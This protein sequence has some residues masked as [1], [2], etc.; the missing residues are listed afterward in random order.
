MKTILSNIFYTSPILFTLM[1]AILAFFDFKTFW[2]ACIIGSLCEFFIIGPLLKMITIK[3][4]TASL[5][6]IHKNERMCFK[7]NGMPSGHT[8]NAVF[9]MV[10]VLYYVMSCSKSYVK[11]FAILLASV[12]IVAGVAWQRIHTEMHSAKQVG[13]GSL[14][15][16]LEGAFFISVYM[17]CEKGRS[18]C[19]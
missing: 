7:H 12:G 13:I 3:T 17:L 1:F 9:C 18:V 15:G 19:K 4:N 16:V 2:I 6:P 11:N 14:V 8:S 5:R 10:L